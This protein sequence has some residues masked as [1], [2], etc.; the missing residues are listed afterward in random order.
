VEFLINGVEAARSTNAPFRAVTPVLPPGNYRITARV[1]DTFELRADSPEEAT[2][3]LTWP[4]ALELVADLDKNGDLI[5]CMG[6]QPGSNYVIQ[7]ATT[8]RE[9]TDWQD[10]LTNGP[11]G[12]ILIFTNHPPLLPQRYFRGRGAP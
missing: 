9:F 4:A 1:V 6:T 10:Y 5:C 2:M 8:L 11:A 7:S 12:G 3:T